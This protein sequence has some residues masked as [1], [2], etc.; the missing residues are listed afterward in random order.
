LTFAIRQVRTA[1]G[2]ARPDQFGEVLQL[3]RDLLDYM[4]DEQFEALAQN[5]GVELPAIESP[6]PN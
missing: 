1:V 6:E 5:Y 3:I 4:S 2:T